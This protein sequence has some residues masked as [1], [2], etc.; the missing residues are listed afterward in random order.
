MKP[1][2]IKKDMKVIGA[3]GVPVGT[4]DRITGDRI[5]LTKQDSG[6]G[7]HQGHHHYIDVGLVAEIEGEMVRLSSSA[8]TTVTFE[9][10]EA[11]GGPTS[12]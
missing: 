8:A 3:D 2:Q 9:E 12:D 5:R 7:R 11:S 10:E 1:S 6:E 4:V